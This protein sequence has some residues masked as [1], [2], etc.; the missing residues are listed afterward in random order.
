VL[1]TVSAALLF[2][3]AAVTVLRFGRVGIGAALVIWLSGLT[4]A[5]TGIGPYVMRALASLA[6]ALTTL[7]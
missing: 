4:A 6:H 3:I 5:S 2:G 1:L 7:H